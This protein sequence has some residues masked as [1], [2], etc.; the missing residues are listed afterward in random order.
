MS[1]KNKTIYDYL[2]IG[3]D[4]IQPIEGLE[5]L[6]QA[7]GVV[8]SRLNR[9]QRMKRLFYLF[10]L[11]FIL[12]LVVFIGLETSKYQIYTILLA[13]A[14]IPFIMVPIISQRIR[15]HELRLKD[16]DLQIDLETY[17]TDNKDLSYA[18]K[19]LRS[20]NNEILKY[21]NM[22]LNQNYWVFTLGII[23][24]ILGFALIIATFWVIST[25]ESDTTL[26]IE[27]GVFGGVSSIMINYIAALY[28][29]MNTEVNGNMKE[30]HARLVDTHMILLGNLIATKITDENLRNQTLS[31]VAKEVCK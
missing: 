29:K 15:E 27:L 1:K 9:M 4:N 6:R 26:Q 7:R 14:L 21:H 8:V 17:A 23:C 5:G 30:F 18:E 12:V 24:I 31:E 13:Y 28:L 16:L 20:H 10:S 11:S 2:F 3:V 22:N 25:V 19:T